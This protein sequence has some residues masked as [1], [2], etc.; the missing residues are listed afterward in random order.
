MEVFKHYKN[1]VENQLGKRIKMENILHHLKNSVQTS[2]IH[3]STTSY[4]SQSNG[5]IECKSQTLKK[6]M[7]VMLISSS[8]PQNL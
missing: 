2:T 6:M 5:V 3:Q 8:L 1:E 4:L 7:N